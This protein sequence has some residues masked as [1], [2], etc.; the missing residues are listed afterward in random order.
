[1]KKFAL[2]MS[3][4]VLS[5]TMILAGCGSSNPSNTASNA[6]GNSAKSGGKTLI[7]GR[8]GDTVTLDPANATDGETFRVTDNIY[9][10]LV[11][12]KPGTF[13]VKPGLATDWSASK[14]GLKWTFHLRK[15]VKFQDG[16]PFN[17]DAVVFNFNRWMDPQNPYHKGDFEYF[18][19]MFGGFKG[20][21]K[22][23]IKDVKK[24]DDYTVEIDLA[25]P[26]A[27]FLA[28][29]TMAAFSIASPA[30]VKKYN[31]DIKDHPIG[32]GPF[33]FVSWKPNDSITLEKNPSYWDT[34]KPKLDK[35]VFQ[36][37]KDNKARLNA[38]QA[39]QIDIMDGLNPADVPT[40]KN[41]SNLQL[42]TRPSNNVGY[43]AFNT[44]K[45]PFNDPRVR[46][47]INMVVDKKALIDAFYNGMAVPA[48]SVLPPSMWG[49]DTSLQDYQVNIQKAKQ[50]LAEAGY[51]NGFKTDLWAMPVARPYM[52]QP[53]KIAAAL[54]ADMKK[55]GID[56]KIVTYDWA[57]Y[58]KK[59]ANGE[60]TM[61]LLGWTGDNGDPDDFL[62]VLLDQDNANPPAQNIAFY[63]NPEVHKLLVQAQQE[64]D[65]NKRADLYKKAEQIIL[66]DAPWVPLVHSTPPMAAS[67]KVTGFVPSPVGSDILTNVDIK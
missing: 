39:G 35:I 58:L 3:A 4:T 27:P 24:L 26:S 7:F 46:Q 59:T 66:K 6:G 37:I 14:N 49:N 55:I 17:A 31:G 43:L 16:T 38:L 8:G 45:K 62:Y 20:N 22:A 30:D 56:A 25:H 19:N 9:E 10:T 50:L 57:T 51:P 60:H 15:N 13:D 21:P 47:A 65:Q 36:V 40:V 5:A 52:P 23:V 67:K 48:V 54:Q 11:A 41:D 18:T 34:G 61:A 28:D 44:Q 12:D 42:F 32:T 2:T 64:T 1:M 29:L 33:K 53:E 63:K